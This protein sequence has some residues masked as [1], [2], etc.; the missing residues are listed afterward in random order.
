L[1]PCCGRKCAGT[2]SP[3]KQVL[4]NGARVGLRDRRKRGEASLSS[5]LVVGSAAAAIIY[6]LR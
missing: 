6:L 5:S 2:A 3:F 4:N 1:K